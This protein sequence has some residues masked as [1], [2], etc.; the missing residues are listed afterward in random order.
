MKSLKKNIIVGLFLAMFIVVATAGLA[1]AEDSVT[2][3][4]A[5][6]G[7]IIILDADDGLYLLEG[8]DM[9]P[10]MVGKKVTVTGTIE[11]KDDLRVIDV[12]SMEEIKE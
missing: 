4:I 5:A 6:K 2:G 11:V 12:L 8:S 1:S 9:T 3:T 7:G 10:D